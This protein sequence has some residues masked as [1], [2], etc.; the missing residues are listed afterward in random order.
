[1]FGQTADISHICEYHWY[2][3]VLFRDSQ[4]KLGH[5]L[6]DKELSEINLSAVTPDYEAYKSDKQTDLSMP[7]T[8]TFEVGDEFE[9]ES[10]DGYITT[11]VLLPRGDY[12]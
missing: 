8:D 4:V 12:A 1:M 6:T 10:Y 3:W 5:P 9:P 2:S 11:Q 7:G